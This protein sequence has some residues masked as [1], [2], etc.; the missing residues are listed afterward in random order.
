GLPI[1]TQLFGPAYY[2]FD[3]LNNH[4]V[5][6]DSSR[7]WTEKTAIPQ[8]EYRWLEADLQK[9]QGRRIFVISHIPS[10]DPRSGVTPNTY[11]ELNQQQKNSLLQDEMKKLSGTSNVDHA[12]ND[13]TEAKKFE[14]LMTKYKVDTVFLSHIHSF[15]SFV[16]GNVRYIITGGAGAELLTKDSYYHYIRVHI[17]N[18]ENYLEIVQLPSPPNQLADRYWAASQLFVSSTYKEYTRLVVDIAIFIT[19]IIGWILWILR[20]KWF[21]FFKKLGLWIYEIAKFSLHKYKEI[22][23]NK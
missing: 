1:Y 4:F 19:L 8:E 22:V 23:R 18:I 21:S 12:F 13:K 10:T 3:Y 11:P 15:F 16:K 6:L 17:T 7:G 9:A 14:D 5:F 2:S 20:Q